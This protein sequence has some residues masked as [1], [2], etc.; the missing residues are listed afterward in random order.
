MYDPEALKELVK[1]KALK[2][3]DFTLVSGRKATYYL[4]GKQV[5]LDATGAR[6][7]GAG[8]LERITDPLPDAVGGMSIGAASVLR[9][10]S[11][12]KGAQTQQRRYSSDLQR[13]ARGRSSYGGVVDVHHAG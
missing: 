1:D 4:D 11:A 3:G 10:T 13:R 2:F 5:T 6:L 7:V 9:R 8:I 12:D